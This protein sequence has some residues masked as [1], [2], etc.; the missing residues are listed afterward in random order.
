MGRP[1]LQRP[2][3]RL[4]EPVGGPA[5]TVS[6][7]DAN[8]L[9][10]DPRRRP[11]LPRPALQPALVLLELPRLGDA[12][13][14]GRPRELRRRE[15]ARRLPGAAEP[16]QPKREAP[17]GARGA[18]SRRSRCRGCS[19]PSPTRAS[20]TPTRWR[21]CSRAS[22]SSARIDVDAKRYVGAQIGI[23]NPSGEKVGTVARL[24]N[25][26]TLLLAGPDRAL[27]ASIAGAA[28]VQPARA[29]PRGA[30]SPP[31]PRP[32]RRAGAAPPRAHR[33]RMRRAARSPRAPP[34]TGHGRARRAGRP[35]TPRGRRPGSTITGWASR[36][37]QERVSDRPGARAARDAKPAGR[38]RAVEGEPVVAQAGDEHGKQ[39]ACS[40]L[41]GPP[42]GPAGELRRKWQQRESGERAEQRSGHEGEVPA[43]VGPGHRDPG[44]P[45]RGED[46]REPERDVPEREHGDDERHRES[47]ARPGEPDRRGRDRQG[48]S[49]Q[50]AG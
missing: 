29:A 1:L 30:G 43:R 17:G 23:Y 33:A 4:P 18:A 9:A 14:L 6:R 16:L 20:T 2:A 28:A 34:P 38:G 31:S 36:T 12:C 32:P 50:P 39:R 46:E 5:G 3:L 21:P 22:V 15:Q 40:R 19:S 10:P 11:R 49:G 42:G 48:P 45:E 13:P 26:E 47:R 37:A 41:H 24:R 8:A 7:L 35:R 44:R 25:R 27:V